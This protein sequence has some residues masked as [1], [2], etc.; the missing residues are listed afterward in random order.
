[1][2]P[3]IERSDTGLAI[4]GD[5]TLE[6]A[7]ALLARGNAALAD[8]ACLFDLAAVSEIDSSGLAV[9]FGWQRAARASGKTLRIANPPE[10][11]IK[12]AKVYGVAEL[13]PL[14]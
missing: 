14:A 3:A 10:N 7:P 12:L 4:S 6:S 8:G 11:L 1:M 5:M 2:N 13:L 9:L